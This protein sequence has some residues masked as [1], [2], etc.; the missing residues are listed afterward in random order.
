MYESTNDLFS[1]FISRNH[2]VHVFRKQDGEGKSKAKG[3]PVIL[4][5]PME[6]QQRSSS[7]STKST[8]YLYSDEL[9]E[10]QKGNTRL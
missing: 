9:G 7:S 3:T 6:D 4:N 5:G 10:I 8:E 1:V 2:F